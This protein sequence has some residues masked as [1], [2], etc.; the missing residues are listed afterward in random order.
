MRMTAYAP[1]PKVANP[2]VLTSIGCSLTAYA[3]SL[4]Y[5]EEAGAHSPTSPRLHVKCK[6]AI[7]YV[8]RERM[9][10]TGN[11]YST[12]TWPCGTSNSSKSGCWSHVGSIPDQLI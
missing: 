5:H 9:C 4:A 12:T 8:G 6:N 7:P 10:D 11:S 2:K 1:L 3:A